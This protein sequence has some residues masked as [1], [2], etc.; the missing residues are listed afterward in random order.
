MPSRS[1]A[2]DSL[3]SLVGL[4][5]QG[6]LRFTTSWLVGRL[7]GRAVLGTVQTAMSTATLLAL[8]GPTSVGSAASKYLARARATEDRDELLAVAAHLRRRAAVLAAALAVVGV[9]FWVQYDDGTWVDGLCVGL[10]TAAYSGYSFTR[11]VQF[12]TGQVRRATSWDVISGVVGVVA[13]LVALTAG[14][15]GAVLLLPLVISY[16]AYTLA[17]WPRVGSRHAPLSPS[18]RRELDEVIALGVAGTLAS[19]GFL[20]IAMIVA[21]GTGAEGA[22]QFAAAMATATPASLLAVSLSL[23]LFPSLAQAWAR[24]DRD[25]FRDQTDRAARVLMMIMV[26]VL[27][28]LA[29]CSALVM[30]V[31]WGPGFDAESPILPTLLLAIMFTTVAVPCVNALVTRSRQHMRITTGASFAGLCTG[32]LVWWA[33]T[34]GMTAE[35]VAAGFLAGSVVS[36]ST[37]L[38]AE[39]RIGGHRWTWVV[40]RLP[41]AVALVLATILAL[42]VLDAPLWAEPLAAL[43]FCAVWWGMCHRDVELVPWASLRRMGGRGGADDPG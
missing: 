38:L 25:L 27:G 29:I 33:L 5:S 34:P 13:L 28:S 10:F 8:M 35:G 32:A 16:T 20:Q 1:L 26:A 18:L 14:A 24:G 36:G 17:A 42:R 9:V 6:L 7:A 39:W 22:G 41:L 11:G 31:L 3:L 43:G 37:P 30:R 12:G 4:L 15:R 2:R 40:L 21:N 23:A 19:A